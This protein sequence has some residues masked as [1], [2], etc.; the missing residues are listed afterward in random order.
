MTKSIKMIG[1]GDDGKQSL[2]PLYQEWINESEILIGGKRH[3]PFFPITA[4]TR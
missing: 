3:L 4:E 1:M 2:L